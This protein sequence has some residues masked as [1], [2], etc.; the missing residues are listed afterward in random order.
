MEE[1]YHMTKEELLK[2]IGSI[3]AIKYDV[4]MK[5]ALELLKNNKPNDQNFFI[6][7]LLL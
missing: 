7:V 1:H 4:R 2:E 6:L 3:E 5:K